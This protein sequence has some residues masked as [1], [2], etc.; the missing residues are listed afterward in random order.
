[1][2]TIYDFGQPFYIA[3]I[4]WFRM[5]DKNHKMTDILVNHFWVGDD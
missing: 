4:F 5:T 1:M 2:S 3:N